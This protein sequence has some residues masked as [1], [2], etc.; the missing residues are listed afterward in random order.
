MTAG[1]ILVAV[2]AAAVAVGV[3][4]AGW[5]LGYRSA[6][7]EHTAALRRLLEGGR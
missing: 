7:R 6:S 1:Q 4:E 5:W 2:Y 3:F